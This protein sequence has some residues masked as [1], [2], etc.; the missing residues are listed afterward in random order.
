MGRLGRP[1]SLLTKFLPHK[2]AWARFKGVAQATHPLLKEL[3]LKFTMATLAAVTGFALLP[4]ASVARPV[5]QPSPV[6]P[7]VAADR[8]ADSGFDALAKGPHETFVRRAAVRGS[9]GF[10]YMSYD[11]TYRGLPVIGGDAVVVTDSRGAV[12]GTASAIGRGVQLTSLTP[13]VPAATASALARKQLDTVE[14]SSSPRL[15]VFSGEKGDRLAFEIFSSGTREGLPSRLRVYID[16]QTGSVLDTRDDVRFGT[17]N[18]FYNGNV[19]IA[20]SGSGASFSMQD[21]TRPGI[22]CAGQTGTTFT[23]TDDNWGNGAGTNLE[24][25]CVD[26]LYAVQKEWDMLSAWLGRNGI[27]GNGG[28]FPA[29]VGLNQVN[30]F[31]NGS[32]TNFGHSSDNQRQATSIDVVAHEYGHAIFQT[33]PGGAGGGNENG[34]INEATGDIFGALTEAFANNPNDPPDFTVGEEVN[35]VGDGPIRFMHNP[36]LAGDPNCWSTAIPGTEVHAAAGPLNHWFYLVSRGSNPPGGPASPICAGG[37]ASVTGIGIQDAGRI[38]YNAMLQKTSTWRYA[39]VRLASLRAAVNLFGANSAQCATVKAAWNAVAVPVQAG[40]P[41]CGQPGPGPIRLEAENATISAGSTVDS[42][43][44]GFSGTGF[45]NT[46]TAVN[47]FVQWSVN[48]ASAGSVPLTFRF[49]NGSTAARPVNVTVN[50]GA[51]MTLNM[52]VTG[53]WTN[54]QTVTITVSLQAGN[55]AVRTTATTA[56]GTANLDFLELPG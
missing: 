11:R 45:V 26:A 35:L 15:V 49:A 53:A 28:G 44:A 34:G 38:Y 17:G 20:T 12:R 29:R 37:P 43:H 21:N 27:N 5:P 6:N 8:A 55:N 51:P 46:P 3:T 14:D 50:G 52:P 36:S 40:E 10:S 7:L 30:A 41:A 24:T 39:N 33:T 48:R 18:G 47:A 16:A 9:G 22:R 25:A 23:G 13:T 1:R 54:W 56:G 4:G 2:V 31:W 32:L 19:T 42:N